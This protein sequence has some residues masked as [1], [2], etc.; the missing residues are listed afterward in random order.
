MRLFP[1]EHIPWSTLG[2]PEAFSELQSKTEAQKSLVKSLAKHPRF[3]IVTSMGTHGSAH[4]SMLLQSLSAQS[5]PFWELYVVGK[6]WVCDDARV[7]FVA[8]PE[9]EAPDQTNAGSA[10]EAARAVCT[11]DWIG[12]LDVTDVL[13]PGALFAFALELER[14]ALCDLIYCHEVH[15]TP[16]YRQVERCYSKSDYSWFNLIHF[17]CVGRAWFAKCCAIETLPPQ[18][19]TSDNFER[20]LFLRLSEETEHWALIPSYLCYRV[21]QRESEPASTSP[22]QVTSLQAHL[23]RKGFSARV[24]HVSKTITVSPT[25]VIP[26]GSLISCIICFRDRADWTIRCLESLDCMKSEIPVEIV[27]VNNG[28]EPNERER[29]AAKATQLSYTVRWI[30]DPRPFNFGQM[31]NDA[32]AH[33]ARGNLIFFLN[34]DVFLDPGFSI[35]DLSR[36]ALQ[37][38]VGVVGVQLRYPDGRIQHSG[39]RALYGGFSRMA[40]VGHGRER[41]VFAGMR[42]E[43]F[44]NTFAACMVKR[45]LYETLGGLRANEYPNGFGDVAFNLE[46]HRRGFHNLYL[47]DLSAIHLESAS[48]GISYEYWEE[49]GLEREF[50]DLLHKMLRADVGYDRVPQA[51]YS[52]RQLKEMVLGILYRKMPRLLALRPKVKQF[53]TLGKL[54]STGYSR[55]S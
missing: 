15:L 25:G 51:D 55:Q 45:S 30:D 8:A 23:A 17:N 22:N 40:R 12:Y 36:W 2:R 4:Q 10:F 31:H 9:G 6:P 39:F 53:L 49:V 19:E 44:G 41:D 21:G 24:R 52:L 48:R 35:D 14:R 16:D 18:S 46:L 38:G 28:S 29:V 5:Y 43:V 13:S 3:C 47:G 50:A 27:L 42:R 7:R 34:N 20:D 26:E 33:I 1:L 11:G 54:T 32:I 37:D